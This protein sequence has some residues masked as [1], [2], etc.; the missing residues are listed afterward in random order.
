MLFKDVTQKFALMGTTANKA[1]LGMIQQ[2]LREIVRAVENLGVGVA[3][4]KDEKQALRNTYIDLI[5]SVDFTALSPIM[6]T[7]DLICRAT[8]DRTREIMSGIRPALVKACFNSLS[9][10]A[11]NAPVSDKTTNDIKKRLN[12][13]ASYYKPQREFYRIFFDAYLGSGSNRMSSH[14]AAFINT[15]KHFTAT[16]LM[17]FSDETGMKNL[18]SGDRISHAAT[19]LD[20]IRQK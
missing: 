6:V 16:L 14:L 8:Q 19:L 15:N 3:H 5:Q 17:I 7:C 1:E 10:H 2:N 12:A 13:Y 9:A 20:Q 11:Q 4:I 18:I